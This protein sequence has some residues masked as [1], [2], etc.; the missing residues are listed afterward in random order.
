MPAGHCLYAALQT[1]EKLSFV[2]GLVADLRSGSSLEEE[3]K[4]IFMWKVR[5]VEDGDRVVLS[6]SG[7]L[8]GPQLS[9][10][11]KVFALGAEQQNLLLDLKDLRLVDHHTVRFLANCE[12]GGASLRNCPAYIREWI[13]AANA[14]EESIPE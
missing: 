6:L 11:Q 7:R 5:R 14:A 10:L 4:R 1:A 9:E 2:S 12:T 3:S 8:E 13:S